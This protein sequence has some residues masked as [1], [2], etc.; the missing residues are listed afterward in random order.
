MWSYTNADSN[1]PLYTHKQTEGR[2]DTH[3]HIH[4]TVLFIHI[5]VSHGALDD[6][7]SV[8]RRVSGVDFGV[9]RGNHYS[10]TLLPTEQTDTMTHRLKIIT[11]NIIA[12][13]I[14][15]TI[16]IFIIIIINIAIILIF[17]CNQ[18]PIIMG[19][20]LTI[21]Y[22]YNATSKVLDL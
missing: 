4:R 10:S 5:K 15:I 13:I 1:I 22:T 11:T 20:S 19:Y 21:T 18:I 3:T 14:N 16:I 12:V 17:I 6:W 7:P 8:S 2:M 9:P